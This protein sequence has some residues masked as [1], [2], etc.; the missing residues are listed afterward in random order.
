LSTKG[1]GSGIGGKV[2]D[3]QIELMHATALEAGR[4]AAES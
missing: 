4:D 1:T 3:A 2:R